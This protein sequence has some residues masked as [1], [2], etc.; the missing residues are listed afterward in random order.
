MAFSV[1]RRYLPYLR[2]YW[3]L[4]AISGVCGVASLV[5]ATAIPLVIKAVIDGP[6]AQRRTG[7]LA[8]YLALLLALAAA[9]FGLTFAR[10]HTSGLASYAMEA[11]MRN[12]FYAHLQGLQVSFHDNWQSGQLLS[13]CVSD[14]NTIRRFIGFGLVFMIIMLATFAVVL[15]MLL[16]LDLVL[17]LIT[18]VAAV[19]VV[20]LSNRFYNDYRSIARQVQDQQGDVTTVIEEM[21]TGVRVIKAFG[22]GSD[23]RRRYEKEALRLRELNLEAIRVRS[24]LWTL[25]VYVPNLNLAAVLLIGGFGVVHGQLS[26]GGLVAFISYL[27]MLNGPM[28]ALGWI[29]SMGEEAR[30]ASDRIDEVYA[31]MRDITDR[32]G[33]STLE[34]STGRIRFEGVGFRYPG[35]EEWILR[36]LDLELAPG[37]T[38]A[39]VGATGSGKT[40]LASLVARLYDVDEGRITLDGVD[41]RE[42]TLSSLRGQLGFA[43]EDPILFSASVRENLLMGRPDADEE[44]IERALAIAQAGFVGD[45]PWGLETRVGEQGYSLSGGQRQRL[46]LAR[47]VL[48]R[49]QVLILDDPLSSVDVHTEA[50]IEKALASVLQGVTALLVVHR[51][52]TLALADRVAL[53]EKGSIAAVGTHHE[54][55]QANPVYKA[56]LSQEAEEMAS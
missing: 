3:R 56:L 53:I 18:A 5:A 51:P 50:L 10:R 12:E 34:T 9:E 7:E 31:T 33:A 47:A 32:P 6:I 40:T 38:L 55:L 27:F 41:I 2:P 35:S 44:E 49:P 14:M 54:L 17:A 43:F 16:R 46:A 48:G 37:E 26:I 15:V 39:L 29:L 11:D 36:G 21:A 20:L 19:P 45:L 4:V 24:G 1:V 25:L 30:T 23:M 42:V 52:S 28:E 22:R 8:P 13:R